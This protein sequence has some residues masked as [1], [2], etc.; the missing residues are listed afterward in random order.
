[1]WAL[2]PRIQILAFS[3]ST[4]V[5]FSPKWVEEYKLV[6]IWFPKVSGNISHPSWSQYH[7]E[8]IFSIPACLWIHCVYEE[9]YS[10]LGGRVPIP[11]S[12]I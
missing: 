10:G 3:K 6:S 7:P 8:S 1:M 11:G 5:F 4:R 2:A 9:E 12:G